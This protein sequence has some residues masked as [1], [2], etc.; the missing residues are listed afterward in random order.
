MFLQLFLQEPTSRTNEELPHRRS[1][2][3]GPMGWPA[4]HCAQ[5]SSGGLVWA[6]SCPKVVAR[7][8]LIGFASVLGLHLVI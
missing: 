5:P 7:L 4:D 1:K 2:A 3:V 6:F 8:V